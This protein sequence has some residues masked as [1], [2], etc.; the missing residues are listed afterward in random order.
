MVEN[1][2]VFMMG[3]VSAMVLGHGLGDSDGLGLEKIKYN[4][5]IHLDIMFHFLASQD[6]L[7]VMGVT[8]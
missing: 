8:E 5:F 2:I 1:A 6:A 4:F 7:E 3:G